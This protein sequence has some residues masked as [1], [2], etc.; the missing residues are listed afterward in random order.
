MKK[1]IAIVSLILSA[2]TIS[3]QE[4][5]PEDTLKKSFS[6]NDYLIFGVEYGASLS[7][8]QFNP[9]K[10][11][12]NL[13]VPHTFGV[14]A[15]KYG[16]LFDGSP[17]FGLKGG[18]RYSHEGYQFKMNKETGITPTREGAEKAIIDIVEVPLMAHF[19]ADGLHFKFMV[20]L[21]IYGGYRL[22][23]ERIGEYVREE[24]A[25]DFLEWDY[26][27]D[28]GITG[29]VGF[30]LVFDPIEF[31]VNAGVRYSWG[32][33]Y[34]ADYLSPDFYRFA[35]PLDFML[36]TGVYF[37]ITKRNG[38]TKGQIRRE[39]YDQVYNPKTNGDFNGQGR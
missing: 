34:R 3:A 28:Y 12:G 14:Y 27:L 39:A 37:Q 22:G 36:T 35:Y 18:V 19:H 24:I 32:S 23:I 8:M 10:T 25:H 9:S 2:W 7:R 20:D 13:F 11:Q 38:K 1:I 30:G 16:K 17:N 6:L 26:R 31:H 33:L 15:V 4:T 29:G 21:G 5:F